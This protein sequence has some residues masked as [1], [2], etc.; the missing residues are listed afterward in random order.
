MNNKILIGALFFFASCTSTQQQK[1]QVASDPST[2]F[3]KFL[4]AYYDQHSQF[5]PLEATANGDN[6]YNNLLPNDLT[7]AYRQQLKSFYQ[8]LQ[9]S[10]KSYD[11]SKLNENDQMSYDVLSWDV[12]KE[13]DGFKY[14][15]YLMPINQFWSL[16]LTMGQLGAGS[17]NQPF[18]TVKDY[19]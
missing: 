6:R 10:L 18:K 14:H 12:N 3:N 8:A 9:D 16:P 1:N 7:V 15:D 19:E 11:R 2:A 17:G 13:L 4:Q 5:Y